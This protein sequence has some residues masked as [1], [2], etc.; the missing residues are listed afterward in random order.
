MRPDKVKSVVVSDPLILNIGSDASPKLLGG[1]HRIHYI[2]NTMRTLA[3][4]VIEHQTFNPIKQL[5]ECIQPSAFMAC[6]E[7]VK[8]LCGYDAVLSRSYR[9]E[10]EL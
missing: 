1:M 6:T 8:R 10:F 3:C 2:S 7:T 4:F 5:A 9:Q